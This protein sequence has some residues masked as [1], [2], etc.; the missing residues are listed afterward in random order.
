MAGRP[1]GRHGVPAGRPGGR[2]GARAR[3][4][5]RRFLRRFAERLEPS[6]SRDAEAAQQSAGEKPAA[7]R[8]GLHA[9]RSAPRL[10]VAAARRPH[11][12]PPEP[13]VRP[14][15]RRRCPSCSSRFWNHPLPPAPPD[16]AAAPDGLPDA[17]ERR[18][19][20]AAGWAAREF[21]LALDAAA[22]LVDRGVPF[23]VTLVEA[24]FGQ[25]RLVRRG[26]PAARAPSSS[27]TAGDR[28][29]GR[30]PARRPC[31]SG[32][33]RPAR[34]PGPRAGRGG[35]P[36]R[37]AGA[38]R[39]RGVRPAVRRAAAAADAR[40]RGRRGR[41]AGGAGGRSRP[42]GS[43]GS[44]P[45]RWP[46]TTPTRS[47]GWPRS[48]RC[49]ADYP[50]EPTFVLAKAAV[51]RDL[52]RQAERLAL[53]E[54]EGRGPGR[55]AD[56]DAVAGPGA[57][58]APEPAGGGDAAAAAVA[59]DPARR[60]PPATTCSA[61]QLV[62]GAGGSPRRPSCTASP[63]AWTTARTSSPT[64][65]PAPPAPWTRCPRPCGCSSSRPAGPRAQPR[66]RPAPCTTPCSTATS[67]TRR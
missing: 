28:R 27:P 3:R 48:T 56:A 22:A 66:P 2:R 33:R 63:A 16:A 11:H 52:N 31:W 39:R 57:A 46:G 20:E 13:R 61:T 25:S 7:E 41:G 60:P 44:C 40:P 23:L 5:G 37:R 38:A 30:S 18:R 15:R 14:H 50:H 36:A 58:A 6:F 34:G 29:P 10:R 9:P 43:R 24:G 32:T 8:G 1:P 64:P 12:P 62:G 17:A 45:S 4:W 19:A 51:L 42:T 67:P 49:L 65:T 59:P 53:L 26:R 35:R 21:T 47:S 55:R 54:A